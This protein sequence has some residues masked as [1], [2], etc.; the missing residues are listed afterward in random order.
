[1]KGYAA[2]VRGQPLELTH[3]DGKLFQLVSESAFAPGQPMTVQLQLTH[4]LT[5][6]LKSIGSTKRADGRFDVRA[7]AATLPR[8][9]RAAL[10]AAFNIG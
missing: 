2:S 4:S 6:D 7:R 1:V 10:L 8:Q 5:L 9:S 3:F